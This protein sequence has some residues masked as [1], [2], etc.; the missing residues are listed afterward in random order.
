MP[1][2]KKVAKKAAKNLAKSTGHHHDKHNQAHDLRRAY[3]HM[4]RVAVLRQASKSSRTDAIAD[5]TTLAQQAIKDG[6]SKAAGDLL[7]ASLVGL[8]N[9]LLALTLAP[10]LIVTLTLIGTDT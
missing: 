9:S 1:P 5:L 2:P 4:G 7:R 8:F 10:T 3:E 6:H